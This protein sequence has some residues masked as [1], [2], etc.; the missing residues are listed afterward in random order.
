MNAYFSLS[1]EWLFTMKP[2]LFGL[3]PGLANITGWLLVI[4]LA[5]MGVCSLPSV[6]KSGYFEVQANIVAQRLLYAYFTFLITH[7]D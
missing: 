4:I 6:R 3:Y 1:I 5:I 2:G 7:T